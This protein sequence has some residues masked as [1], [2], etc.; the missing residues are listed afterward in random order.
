[1]TK[2]HV[3]S[4]AVTWTGNLGE[5]TAKERAYSRNH[6]IQINGKPVIHCSSDPSFRGDPTRYNPEELLVASLSACHMLWY[7][8]LC[9]N[10]G[11]GVIAYVDAPVGVMEE[12]SDGSRH[13]AEV[14]LKPRVT[15]TR[16]T[17]IK[18]AIRLHEE[19]HKMCFIANS[20]NFP[21]QHSAE[22]I[23]GENL[24]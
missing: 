10:I 19:A 8:H 20:L 3:Y 23:C 14:T 24:E 13:F 1:M 5:G 4:R 15:I 22:I 11:I 6:D 7:L 18:A 16:Q 2:T 9:T 12:A 21:V 17:D